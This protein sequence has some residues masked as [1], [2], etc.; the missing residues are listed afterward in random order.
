M[1]GVAVGLP[2]ALIT[3]PVCRYLGQKF[4]IEPPALEDEEGSKESTQSISLPSVFT[5]LSILGGPI[6]IIVVASF[7]EGSIAA[8]VPDFLLT[9][10]GKELTEGL[11]KKKSFDAALGALKME[12]SSLAKFILFLGHPIIALLIGTCVAMF[13]LG[14]K[15]GLRGNALMEVATKALGPAGIIILVTGAG[16]V[17]KQMLI[18]TKVGDALAAVLQE[19]GFGPLL[20]AWILTTII[21]IAQGSATVAM[22]TGAALISPLLAAGDYS[23]AQ[24][25]LVTIA[26]AAGA[27][28]FGHVNDSGFWI[29]NRYFRMTERETLLTW[30]PILTVISIV[31]LGISS[32]LWIF[33]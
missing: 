7:V 2:T 6:L 3:I 32:V 4:H 10:Q 1:W 18:S 21:R 33:V 20:L 12:S 24:L 5:I 28:G 25:A 11:D 27:T 29:V 9:E 26:I 13:V 23:T 8:G 17:Y 31:G 15:R 16:G 14:M 30:T 22:V 19:T